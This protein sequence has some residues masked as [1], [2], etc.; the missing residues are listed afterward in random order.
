LFNSPFSSSL[1]LV[2]PV[3]PV[4]EQAHVLLVGLPAGVEKIA[5]ERD[6]ADDA[7]H[8]DVEAHAGHQ[9][10]RRAEP[11]RF[12]EDDARRRHADQIADERHEADDRVQADGEARAG[13]RDRAVEEPGEELKPRARLALARPLRAEQLAVEDRFVS[14]G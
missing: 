11:V 14:G 1:G 2:R 13:D 12:H 4:G 10:S 5:G 7:F 3:H 8:R 6:Q 9:R